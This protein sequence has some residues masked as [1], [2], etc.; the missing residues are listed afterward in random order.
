MFTLFWVLV[1]V[2]RRFS[3][4]RIPELQE[5]QEVKRFS[6]FVADLSVRG[7]QTKVEEGSQARTG[8]RARVG[9]A[10]CGQAGGPGTGCGGAGGPAEGAGPRAGAVQ[11]EQPAERS[12]FGRSTGNGV[13]I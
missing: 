7:S 8:R 1:I 9:G 6:G 12:G 10:G 3:T 4:L 2:I 11:E 13:N 5:M